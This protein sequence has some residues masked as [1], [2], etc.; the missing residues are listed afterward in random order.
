MSVRKSR[1]DRFIIPSASTS[2]DVPS[3]CT[4]NIHPPVRTLSRI[5]VKPGWSIGVHVTEATPAA[6]A[7]LGRVGVPPAR[8]AARHGRARRTDSRRCRPND[9]RGNYGTAANRADLRS[10]VRRR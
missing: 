9:G 2:A 5:N 10:R 8:V 3:R 6:A 1:V 4:P 7:R